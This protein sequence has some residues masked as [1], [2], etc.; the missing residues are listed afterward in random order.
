MVSIII[1]N[2]FIIKIQIRK[3][4]N[5]GNEALVNKQGF[6]A[7]S[8]LVLNSGRMNHSGLLSKD[9]GLSKGLVMCLSLL[10]AP[11]PLDTPM[12]FEEC[13][14]PLNIQRVHVRYLPL[15][16]ALCDGLFIHFWVSF[17]FSN[18][19]EELLIGQLIDCFGFTIQDDFIIIF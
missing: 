18:W 5:S 2:N 16:K 17:S 10:V 7:G 8:F 12:S 11:E 15:I 1:F 6:E 13:W 9:G 14:S 3:N 4:E 19:L